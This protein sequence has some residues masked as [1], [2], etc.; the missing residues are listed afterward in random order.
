[1]RKISAHWHTIKSSEGTY[2]EKF[3]IHIYVLDDLQNSTL[4]IQLS[5][6]EAGALLNALDETLSIPLHKRE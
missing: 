4:E 1:M 2:I 6:A 3:K 5:E